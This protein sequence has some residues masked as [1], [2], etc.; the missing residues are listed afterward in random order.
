MRH[1]SCVLI[2]EPKLRLR[3]ALLKATIR[4]GG[5]IELIRS[6][7]HLN[8]LKHR[9]ICSCSGFALDGHVEACSGLMLAAVDVWLLIFS[10]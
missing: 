4:N 7:L 6:T 3:H 8:R 1:G 5:H 9:L 2:D 10:A